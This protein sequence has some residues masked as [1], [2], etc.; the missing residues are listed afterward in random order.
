MARSYG[1]WNIVV[2]EAHRATEFLIR[3]I[4]CL[5][6]FNPKDH[7]HHDISSHVQFLIDHLPGGRSSRI[8]FVIGAY[9][10]SRNKYGYGLNLDKN[11]YAQ[12][13]KVVDGV[14]SQLGSTKPIHSHKGK[15]RCKLEIDPP[16]VK[17]YCNDEYILTRTDYSLPGP[18]RVIDKSFIR[19]PTTTMVRD[20]RRLGERLT[21]KRNPAYYS[22]EEFRE[23]D[24]LNAIS[25]MEKS[26]E[27][28]G[29]FFL[30]D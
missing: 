30:L 15:V 17:V 26:F 22:E 18:F 6:E 4:I 13:L 2:Y 19:R 29:A 12:V 28:A 9:M 23:H 11:N 5:L 10:D 8:P 1:Y 20:L 21:K 7:P 24:A 27:I 25:Y 14:F 16:E 3:G